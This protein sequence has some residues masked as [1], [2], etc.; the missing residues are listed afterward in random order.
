MQGASLAEAAH[1][2]GF[3]DSAHLARTSRRMFG[4]PPSLMDVSAPSGAGRL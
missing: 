2:S 1:A 3:A 4:I